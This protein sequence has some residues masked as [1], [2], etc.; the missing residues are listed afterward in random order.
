MTNGPSHFSRGRL[1]SGHRNGPP[2]IETLAGGVSALR[3]DVGRR[4]RWQ[5]VAKSAVHPNPLDQLL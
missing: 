3:R 1:L 5:I 2:D 4:Q